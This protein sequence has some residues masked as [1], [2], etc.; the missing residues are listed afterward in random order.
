VAWR[1]VCGRDEDGSRRT[2]GVGDGHPSGASIAR[3]ESFHVSLQGLAGTKLCGEMVLRG[4]P[5]RFPALRASCGHP[6]VR[7]HELIFALG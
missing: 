1:G 5:L 4:L 3:D 2:P 6:G 7:A